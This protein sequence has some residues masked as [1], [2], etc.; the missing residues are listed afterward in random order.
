MNAGH[1]ATRSKG[2]LSRVAV[3]G[4]GD[5]GV[6]IPGPWDEENM[7]IDLA[8]LLVVRG[9]AAEPPPA[10]DR[11]LANVATHTGATPE[12]LR[13][14]LSDLDRRGLL[15]EPVDR[16]AD[17][18]LADVPRGG[19]GHAGGGRTYVLP[20]P[21][22]LRPA[23]DGFRWFDHDGILQLQLDPRQV[24][25]L[26]EFA[27]SRT[28]AQAHEAHV[29]ALGDHALS[30]AAFRDL[31]SHALDAGLLARYDPDGAEQTATAR[32]A[33]RREDELRRSILVQQAF[34]R[35]EADFD[36]TE[37]ERTART[38][39]RRVPV[40]SVHTR[41]S[42]PPA[43]L[44]MVVAYAKAHDGGV[45]EDDYAFHP[46]LLQD[47]PKLAAMAAQPGV[48]LFSNYIWCHDENKVFSRDVK[49]V[50]SRNV[51]I[52]GGPDTPKYPND[53][54][55]YF[56]DHR[57]VDITVRG[58]G[59]A[60]LV[61]ILEAL[62]GH[63]GDGPPDL[64]PLHDVPGL[65]FR[66]GGGVVHTP[67]RDRIA[68]LDTI[69]SPVLT[70]LF[71]GFAD[72][73]PAAFMILESNRGCPYGCTFCD[74]GSNTLSRIRKFDLQR[75]YDELEWCANHEFNFVVFADANFGIF[76]RDVELAEKV[77]ELKRTHGWPRHVATNY[78]KNTVK[79]LSK[80]I[81]IFASAGIVSEGKVSLQTMDDETLT[82]IRRKNIKVE[83]YNDLS[84]EFRKRDLPL[85]VELM[86]GLPGATAAS[87][88]EDLQETIARDVRAAVYPTILLPNSPMNDPAYR[89][90]NGIRV[91]P[92]EEVDETSSYTHD[93][94][95]QMRRL[96]Q[97]FLLCDL[98]GVLRQVA[99]FVHQEAGIREVDLYERLLDAARDDPQRF[100][101][102]ALTFEVIPKYMVPPVSWT[103]FLDEVRS[104]L[105]EDLGVTPSSAL[106]TVVAVQLALLPAR[107]RQFPIEVA[108]AH[109]YAAWHDEVRAARDGGHRHDWPSVV[110]PLDSFG[111][112]SF[113][114]DDPHGVC[115]SAMSEVLAA[116]NLQGG[117]WEFGSPVSRPVVAGP[118]GSS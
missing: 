42:L 30:E 81:E 100:P 29:G 18:R 68:D 17:R 55:R 110:P 89:E 111:P 33:A 117:W 53:V 49:A 103:L 58:E 20:V 95:Q 76:E 41:W 35:I 72:A 44:G 63:V 4:L 67:D 59:E 65:S 97:V 10:L 91:R 64:E 115:S 83:K 15:I 86:M 6:F 47:A 46:R 107:E 114:V 23:A 109:D 7:P 50:D 75:I 54:E 69:P 116:L 43:S 27:L 62:R 85:S 24:L 106:D 5:T 22:F 77:A 84:V 9:L 98:F 25:A 118:T 26:S 88:R 80:I 32:E 1:A 37:A 105:V 99:T 92:G 31:A 71:D 40:V 93:E 87:F 78:A 14:F 51:T 82:V 60:T 104:F 45:L 113:P 61:H 38:G 112:M 57:H 108:L 36:A 8:R 90:A 70:G 39:S 11:L 74:W 21:T 16:G 94:W 3:I 79:H 28:V 66:W 34:D 96:T 13:T 101:T 12:E 56:A 2:A 102:V 19:D 73:G 52:H 48:F